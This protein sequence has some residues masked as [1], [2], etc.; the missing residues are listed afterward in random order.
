MPPTGRTV[1][2]RTLQIGQ[3]F[4]HVVWLG[5]ETKLL[6]KVKGNTVVWFQESMFV[7]V[8]KLYI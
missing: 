5:M 7:T 1:S 3:F 6:C 8:I 4:G 2:A